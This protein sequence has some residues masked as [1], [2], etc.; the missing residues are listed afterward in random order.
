[1]QI[2]KYFLDFKTN[3]NFSCILDLFRIRNKKRKQIFPQNFCWFYYQI[4]IDILG[5]K[6]YTSGHT[7]APIFHNLSTVRSRRKKKYAQSFDRKPNWSWVPCETKFDMIIKCQIS[8]NSGII[9]K[10]INT[11]IFTL[12]KTRSSDKSSYPTFDIHFLKQNEMYFYLG[13]AV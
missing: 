5:I 10:I 1:M 11:Y 4:K 7:V 3:K 13:Y 8:Q 12:Y 2:L 6:V 9:Q